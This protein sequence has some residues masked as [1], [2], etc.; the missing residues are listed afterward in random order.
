MNPSVK[1]RKENATTFSLCYED[2]CRI[3]NR[4]PLPLVMVHLKKNILDFNGD[5]ITYEEWGP[6]LNALSLDR[7][8]HFIG[9]RS[10]RSA[11]TAMEDVATEARVK[12]LERVP[13]LQTRYILMLLMKALRSCMCNTEML[14]C[15]ELEGLPVGTEYLKELIKGVTNCKS[16]QNI[17]F[18]RSSI[19]DEGCE[20]LC[21]AIKDLSNII[22]VDLSNCGLTDKGAFAVAQ[23]LKYQKIQ[24]CSESWKQVLRYREPDYDSLPGLRRVT[25]NHNVKI[26][27]QGVLHIIDVMR[28]DFFLKD[29]QN[30]GVGRT[31]G[32][33][34]LD[35]LK[36]NVNL[37][38]LDLRANQALNP[39][40]LKA[41]MIQL[42]VNN[43]G[44]PPEYHW[45]MVDRSQLSKQPLKPALK[46]HH[47][48]RSAINRVA[49]ALSK[50]ASTKEDVRRVTSATSS[51]NR[52]KP[53]TKT[54]GV[55]WHVSDRLD[56]RR[57]RSE[58]SPGTPRTLQYQEPCPPYHS[59]APPATSRCVELEL[60][61][62]QLV[63]LS[64][65]LNSEVQ[66]RTKLEEEKMTLQK[67]LDAVEG[68]DYVLVEKKVITA[69]QKFVD[70]YENI[71]QRLKDTGLGGLLDTDVLN[72]MEELDT[73]RR[74]R[75][76]SFLM[77]KSY[78]EHAAHKSSQTDLHKVSK[79]ASTFRNRNTM[80]HIEINMGDTAQT[81]HRMPPT[82]GNN[83]VISSEGTLD[84]FTYQECLSDSIGASGEESDNLQLRDKLPSKRYPS[85]KVTIEGSKTRTG[86]VKNMRSTEK[87]RNK[88][89][90]KCQQD[91]IINLLYQT[92]VRKNKQ[93][94]V[95]R[96][97]NDKYIIPLQPPTDTVLHHRNHHHQDN[98]TASTS[99]IPE[100]IQ[101]E[102]ENNSGLLSWSTIPNP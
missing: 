65:E 60:A 39:D 89:K 25:L 92:V 51:T 12:A 35:M 16:L 79:S 27:D 22:S 36:T 70:D 54:K 86:C 21:R 53:F 40:L 38:V 62:K 76:A 29:L 78:S 102:E 10:I 67:Q 96:N 83:V 8:L 13:V 19:G 61:K 30:C 42:H 43:N 3:Q 2:I 48:S 45:I 85:T 41:I 69:I 14:T 59:K 50:V 9:I 7:S 82:E 95:Q 31:G 33:A 34:A 49:S 57:E 46:T 75:L 100:D 99:S 91:D 15:I 20:L 26:G 90:K 87:K 98:S 71:I 84:S 88:N 18:H 1:K 77:K 66:K 55:P 24:R 28:D 68:Q 5:R 73:D 47:N 97:K 56:R 4:M 6:I 81:A 52:S 72:S 94:E 80:P 44:I 11:K 37:A 17:S 101:L 32:E 63:W 93:M 23:V 58:A 74:A 64:E